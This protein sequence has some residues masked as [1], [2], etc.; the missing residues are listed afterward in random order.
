MAQCCADFWFETLLLLFLPETTDVGLA[1]E[2]LAGVWG[3]CLEVLERTAA[4]IWGFKHLGRGTISYPAKVCI[5]LFLSS[6]LASLT[7][8]S[9]T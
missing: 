2:K 5:Y 9:D 6:V 3:S 4:L 1:S 7:F 8:E